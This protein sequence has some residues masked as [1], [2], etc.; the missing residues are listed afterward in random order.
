MGDGDGVVDRRGLLTT[1]RL[2]VEVETGSPLTRGATVVDV[3]RVTGRSPNAHVAVDIDGPAFADRLLE[4][5][6]RLP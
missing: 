3:N 5:L 2:N 6:Y 4:R 1:E